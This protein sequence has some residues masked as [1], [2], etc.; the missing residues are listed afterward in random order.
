[1]SKIW[2]GPPTA[3][4]APF[5]SQPIRDGY[6]T[7]MIRPKT[8]RTRNKSKRM[9]SWRKKRSTRLT[10]DFFLWPLLLLLPADSEEAMAP[11]PG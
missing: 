11:P 5:A 9:G 7:E 8:L 3:T 10:E 2:S 6:L 1:M 4:S